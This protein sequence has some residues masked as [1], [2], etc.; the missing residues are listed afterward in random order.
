MRIDH[1]IL[2]RKNASQRC[3]LDSSKVPDTWR[4]HTGELRHSRA[5]LGLPS[6]RFVPAY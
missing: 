2:P 1:A 6:L 4:Q 5:V 3:P